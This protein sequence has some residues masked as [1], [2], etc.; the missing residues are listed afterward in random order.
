MIRLGIGTQDLEQVGDRFAAKALELRAAGMMDQAVRA[1]FN[2]I[3][4]YGAEAELE[5]RARNF[6]ARLPRQRELPL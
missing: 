4:C 2:A 3:I 6:E 5:R 1:T